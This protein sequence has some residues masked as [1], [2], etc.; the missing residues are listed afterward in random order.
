MPYWGSQS[1][2]E[3]D[4][5]V[6]RVIERPVASLSDQGALVDCGS[7]GELFV[8]RSQLPRYIKEGDRLR[9]FLY[10]DSGR[11]LATARKPLLELGMAGRLRVASVDCGTAY[12]DMGIPKQLVVPISEQRYEF[13]P[14]DLVPI[15]VAMDSYGRLFGTQRFNRYIHELPLRG[16][17]RRFDRVKCVPVARTPLGWR[18]VIDDDCYGVMYKDAEKGEVELGRRYDGYIIMIRPDGRLDVSL[19]EPGAGGVDH[20]ALELMQAL[21]H[22]NGS[23]GFNDR[24]D[25]R[26]IEDYLHMSK[27]KFKKAI[28]HL[29]K[30]RLIEILPDG[31]KLTGKG[32]EEIEK[33]LH[34]SKHGEI[35]SE[36]RDEKVAEAGKLEAVEKKEGKEGSDVQ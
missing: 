31:I 6:G 2:Y 33:R 16:R 3:D 32:H 28:G 12:L 18:A 1:P 17:Y 36:Q 9:V 10:Q 20:A 7:H 21:E 23:L 30:L 11:V 29:Y 14:G 35:E 26:E 25:P 19:Q 27:G 24:S 34:G 4:V 8:P 13:E 5:P 15:F 22:S